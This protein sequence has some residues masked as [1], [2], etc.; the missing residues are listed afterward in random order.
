MQPGCSNRLHFYI[1]TVIQRVLRK[2]PSHIVFSSLL[3]ANLLFSQVVLNFLHTKN[4]EQHESTAGIEGGQFSIHTHR[5]HCEVCS[6]DVL[7]NLLIQPTAE[8]E[9]LQLRFSPVSVLYFGVEL[10]LVSSVQDRA[11]PAPL[12]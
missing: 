1:C 8:L 12:S 6:L 4:T 3:I 2:R 10:T 7:F 11:P 9:S 5:E